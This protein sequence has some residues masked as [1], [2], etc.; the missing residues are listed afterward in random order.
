MRKEY[1]INIIKGN[2]LSLLVTLILAS[3]FALASTYFLI[4]DSLVSIFIVIITS[5]SIFSGGFYASR[6]SK[7]KGYLSGFLVSLIY[8]ILIGIYSKAQ[9]NVISMDLLT[10]SR[11]A[12]GFLVGIFSG[13]LGINL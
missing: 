11:L 8:L 12:L 6:K 1:F 9:G 13:M 7:R 10:F 4:G 2:I 5:I 3:V